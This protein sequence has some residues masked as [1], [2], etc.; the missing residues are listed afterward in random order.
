MKHDSEAIIN[1]TVAQLLHHLTWLLQDIYFGGGQVVPT[2]PAGSPFE[3]SPIADSIRLI[4]RAAN[5]DLRPGDPD[6]ET[7]P[8]VIQT[9]LERLFSAPLTNQYTIPD[10]F[11]SRPLGRAILD[12][13]EWLHGEDYA[14]T[15]TEAATAL[16]G[17]AQSKHIQAVGRLVETG[18]LEAWIDPDQPN[19]RHARRVSRASVEAHR[20][21]RAN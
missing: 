17:S 10:W 2:V 4:C 9:L 3:Q 6:A 16:Y 7:L 8:H 15:I 11:W 13:R 18:T 21:S 14:M 20:L 12:A 19:P 5:G 1:E